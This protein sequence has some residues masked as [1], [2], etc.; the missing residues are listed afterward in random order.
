M[1]D[2]IVEHYLKI[3]QNKGVVLK[4][5]IIWTDN[6][7][8]QYKCRH[9]IFQVVT[10]PSRFESIEVVT[11]RYA[12]VFN[13]KGGHDSEGRVI[14][15]EIKNGELNDVLFPTALECFKRLYEEKISGNVGVNY[16]ELS[17]NNYERVF[18]YSPFK[19]SRRYFWYLTECTEEIKSLSQNYER[20]VHTDHKSTFQTMKA[21]KETKK[22]V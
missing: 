13:F 5:I 10:L 17:R 9:N 7:S 2:D 6:C 18:D 21:F 8:G 15:E 3:F 1:L 4:R 22:N 20:V 11:H 16:D 19:M 12:Q 14:K